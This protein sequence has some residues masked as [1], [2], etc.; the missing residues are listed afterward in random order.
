MREGEVEEG[1]GEVA[2]LT[3]PALTGRVVAYSRRANMYYNFI[4]NLYRYPELI[5]DNE[6]SVQ[7]YPTLT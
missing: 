5:F 7:E 1:G 4:T 3:D 6:D 2:C